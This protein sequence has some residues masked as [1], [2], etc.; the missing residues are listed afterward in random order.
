LLAHTRDAVA[1]TPRG[2]LALLGHS[3]APDHAAAVAGA[4]EAFLDGA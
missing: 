2:R 1:L 4:I 3:A